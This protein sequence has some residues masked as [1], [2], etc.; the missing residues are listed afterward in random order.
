MPNLFHTINKINGFADLPIGWKFGKGKSIDGAKRILAKN[1]LE[2]GADNDIERF[3]AF[4]G[5]DGE[6]LVSFY[7]EDNVLDITLEN[8]G[9]VTV[10]EDKGDEQISFSSSLDLATA[11]KKLWEFTQ[12]IQNIFESSILPTT[13]PSEKSLRVSPSKLRTGYRL[14]KPN[15][16]LRRAERFALTSPGFINKE[17]EFPLSFG[18]Y[19]IPIF[20]KSANS[21][22]A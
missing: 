8:D 6:L 5:E 4:A 1:F 3:N 9:S 20:Q 16:R 17:L 11:Y 13:M 19:L 10:A 15:A 22:Q 12:K 18:K 2:Y 21:Y 14:S 7:F